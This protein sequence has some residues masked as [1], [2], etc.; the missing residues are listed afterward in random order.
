MSLLIEQEL[1]VEAEYTRLNRFSTYSKRIEYKRKASN[2]PFDHWLLNVK[3]TDP[4]GM[5]ATT[6]DSLVGGGVLPA[7]KTDSKVDEATT[8]PNP[9]ESL[10]ID[11]QKE[12]TELSIGRSLLDD[13]ETKSE[14]HLITCVNGAP[15]R[16]VLVREHLG[17]AKATAEDF[18]ARFL[19]LMSEKHLVLDIG[20]NTGQ[21]AVPMASLGHTVISFEPNQSTCDILRKNLENANVA[22]RVEVHCAL[23]AKLVETLLFPRKQ[24]C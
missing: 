18:F 7:G 23:A 20:A 10:R 16:R 2:A 19:P 5:A 4:D 22:S 1:C 11:S 13:P 14:A 12:A 9:A 6:T 21:F 17:I 24:K 8:N 15:L 3:G